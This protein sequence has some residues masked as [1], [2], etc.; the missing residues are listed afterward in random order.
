MGQ[1]Q[2]VFTFRNKRT[3]RRGIKKATFLQV[4][5][6]LILDCNYFVRNNQLRMET[7]AL[8]IPRKSAILT[9]S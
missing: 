3:S 8:I 9:R 1:G 5:F 7:S 6:L 4:A 2:G